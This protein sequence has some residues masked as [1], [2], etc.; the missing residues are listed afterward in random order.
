MIA[1]LLLAAALP[2]LYTGQDSSDLVKLPTP[3]VNYRMDMASATQAPWIDANG[4]RM[5]R[6]PGK[7]F[8]YDVPEAAVQLAMAEAHANNATAVLKIPET[9]HPAFDAMASF[10]KGLHQ[11]PLPRLSNIAVTDDGSPQAGEAMNLLARKNL[12]FRIVPAPDPKADLNLALNKSIGN[13]LEFAMTARQKLT[14]EKRWLRLYGSEVV[15][16]TMYGDSGTVRVH[17]VNYGRRPVDGMRIRV[18]GSYP[19]A[20]ASIF[21]VTGSGIQDLVSGPDSTEFTIS[22]L[23]V[24]A[25]IE[26]TSKSH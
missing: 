17:V 22:T 23:P 5:Q 25:V 9:A 15:L 12:L 8:L 16:A 20:V 11:S 1:A 13:P 26:L 18:K 24:Y 10:L 4:W 19:N 7:T 6:S 14:D 3:V 21:G 2:T